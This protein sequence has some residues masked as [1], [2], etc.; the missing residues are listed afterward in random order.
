VRSAK[1]LSLIARSTLALIAT[2]AVMSGCSSGGN[3]TSLEV[4]DSEE[5]VETRGAITPRE[6]DFNGELP[7]N[8]FGMHVPL[9]ACAEVPVVAKI[10]DCQRGSW[11][12]VKIESLRLWDSYTTWRD[13]ELRSGVYDWSAL[14]LAVTTAEKNDASILLVLGPTPSWS[15]TTIKEGDL[16]GPGSAAPPTYFDDFR[17]Y[18]AAVA[19]RYQGRIGAYQIWNEANL[20]S[21]WRGTPEQMAELTK[22]AYDAVKNEDPEALVVAASTTTRAEGA[23]TV[24]FPR[25]LKELEALGW[26]VDVFSAHAYPPSTMSPAQRVVYLRQVNKFLEEAYAPPLPLWDTEVNYGLAGPGPEYPDVDLRGATQAAWLAQSYFDSIRTGVTR[27]YWF[28]WSPVSP[29]SLLGV[30]TWP[31]TKAALTYQVIQDWLVGANW[32]GCQELNGL[33]SCSI[34]NETGTGMIVWSQTGDQ[35]WQSPSPITQICRI[36]G[37][38]K[39][40]EATELTAKDAPVLAY[41]AAAE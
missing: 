35:T 19:E 11:P 23:F 14:D 20:K 17:S 13:I 9:V 38:C 16:K 39:K 32:G 34:T 33:I 41:F 26:P 22:I 36:D 29:N 6:L 8:M 37:R 30:I 2:A 1:Q 18:V 25:Y 24:W 10:P 27:T 3:E 7:G 28:Q 5:I 40:G 21:F 31:G 15:A 12:D 4:D